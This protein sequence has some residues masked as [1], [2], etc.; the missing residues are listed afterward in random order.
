MSEWSIVQS[1][2]GCVQKCTSGSN[3][4]LCANQNSIKPAVFLFAWAGFSKFYLL[5]KLCLLELGKPLCTRTLVSLQLPPKNCRPLRSLNANPGTL[6]PKNSPFYGTFFICWDWACALH[7]IAFSNY[8][9]LYSSLLLSA[10]AL[11]PK[12]IR[13]RLNYELGIYKKFRLCY[14]QTINLGE[15]LWAVIIPK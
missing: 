4:D 9:N 12:Y 11:A 1:W 2:N 8:S 13:F 14:T 7:T 15:Y 10:S 6:T 3:P 5:S